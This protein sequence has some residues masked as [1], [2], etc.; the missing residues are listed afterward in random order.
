MGFK[1][2]DWQFHSSYCRAGVF[3]AQR[4]WN[5]LVGGR[6]RGEVGGS[7]HQGPGAG[8]QPWLLHLWALLPGDAGLFHFV[9]LEEEITYVDMKIESGVSPVPQ[10]APEMETF[11][12]LSCSH[13]FSLELVG[14]KVSISLDF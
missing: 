11:T 2:G 1:W 6:G 5:E 9:S 7:H 8:S 13:F 4:I 10:M 12:L 14:D 3:Q